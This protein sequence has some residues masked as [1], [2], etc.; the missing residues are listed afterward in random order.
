MSPTLSLVYRQLPIEERNI[1]IKKL[2]RRMYREGLLGQEMY[3]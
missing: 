2:K 1:W 3:N